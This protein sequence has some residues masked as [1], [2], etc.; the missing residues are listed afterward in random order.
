[1]QKVIV[2]LGS[3]YKTAPSQPKKHEKVNYAQMKKRH[4]LFLQCSTEEHK[5]I[6]HDFFNIRSNYSTFKLHWTRFYKTQFVPCVSDTPLTL[7]P[8]NS[9]RMRRKKR[10][11]GGWGGGGG[12]AERGWGGKKM[13]ERDDF[14]AYRKV[15]RGPRRTRRSRLR[16]PS[17]KLIRSC[18][19]LTPR[20]FLD[21]ISSCTWL[22]SSSSVASF[23]ISSCPRCTEFWA[24]E[25][26]FLELGSL[27]SRSWI[28]EKQQHQNPPETRL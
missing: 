26:H 19:A 14:W 9:E 16:F 10:G 22:R 11:G 15:L 4:V 13:T 1:M 6:A 27:I 28:K 20:C 18:V 8:P 5:H 24:A 7:K 21:I 2:T 12:W 3:V 17:I 25:S 23:S